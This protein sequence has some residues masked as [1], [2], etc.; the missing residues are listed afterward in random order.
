[1]SE[2]VD[3]TSV[4]ALLDDLYTAADGLERIFPGRKFT[5]DGH[6]VGSIGEVVAAYMFD[7]DLNPAS[8]QGHDARARD[9]RQVEIKLTQGRGV[10]IRHEPEHLI[11]LHRPAGG[12][13]RVVFNGPGPVA[14]AG[15]GKMQKNGQRPIS[16]SRLAA[17][18]DEIAETDRLPVLRGPPV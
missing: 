4:A 1:M 5:L 13:I 17:L 18:S 7:L 16:L 8:T 12:P 9:G 10:A 3:W 2:N 15:A 11:V 14:W 6:L